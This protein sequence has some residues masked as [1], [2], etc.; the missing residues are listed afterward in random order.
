MNDADGGED[1]DTNSEGNKKQNED[2]HRQNPH[3]LLVNLVLALKTFTRLG[4]LAKKV[5]NFLRIGETSTSSK[6]GF[7]E[8]R[9]SQ[10][11]EE[12]MAFFQ[13]C[14]N[15]PPPASAFV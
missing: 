5:M 4:I 13:K 7:Q 9:K 11:L 1:E 6:N 14:P 15:Q 12:P 2:D 3:F 10:P 8:L